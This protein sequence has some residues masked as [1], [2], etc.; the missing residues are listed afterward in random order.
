MMQ[1]KMREPMI[2]DIMDEVRLYDAAVEPVPEKPK[3]KP[4]KKDNAIK[5]I[6]TT[7][8]EIQL[9]NNLL[10]GTAVIGLLGLSAWLNLMSPVLY[11]PAIVITLC[12]MSYKYGE[13]KGENK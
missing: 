8:G 10:K 1:E 12:G 3:A 5:V 2:D 9:R 11:V 4:I 6:R 13:W 7:G